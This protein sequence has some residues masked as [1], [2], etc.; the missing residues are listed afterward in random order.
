MNAPPSSGPTTE[1]I[2]KTAAMSPWKTLLF[3]NGTTAIRTAIAPFIIPAA[4]SPVIAR[5]RINTTEDGAAPL[6]A[7]PTSKTPIA[8]M[9]MDFGELKGKGSRVVMQR[10]YRRPQK[11]W[12]AQSV[13]MYELPYQPMWLS[14]LKASVMM[15]MAGTRMF[16]S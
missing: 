11:S 8:V 4:P 5:P 12:K 6:I 16:L 3:S 2:P 1:A 14:E 15:G 7:D 13:S 9:K 10:E